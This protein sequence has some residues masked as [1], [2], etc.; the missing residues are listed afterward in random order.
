MTDTM[1]R[2]IADDLPADCPFGSHECPKNKI[3]DDKVEKLYTTVKSLEKVSWVCLAMI[4]LQY[5]TALI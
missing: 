1:D 3:T 4:L 2:H 5:G